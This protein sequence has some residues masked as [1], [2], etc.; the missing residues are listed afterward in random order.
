MLGVN[1]GSYT[2]VSSA[3]YNEPW[4]T[5]V[6]HCSES[7]LHLLQVFSIPAYVVTELV[8]SSLSSV[9]AP[10]GPHIPVTMQCVC[11]WYVCMLVP[12]SSH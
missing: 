1:S 11:V 9:L 3:L 2:A 4:S 10:V 12:K 8:G 6:F 5:Q 7:Q